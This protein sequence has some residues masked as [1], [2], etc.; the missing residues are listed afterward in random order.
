VQRRALL[1]RLALSDT[2]SDRAATIQLPLRS[3]F[4]T[5]PGGTTSK[6]GSNQVS[7]FR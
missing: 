7:P 1:A 4:T 6:N 5:T 3:W 2:T